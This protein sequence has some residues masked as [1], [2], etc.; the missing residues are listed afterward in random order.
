MT[1]TTSAGARSNKLPSDRLETKFKDKNPLYTRGEAITEANRCI[2]CVDAP[3]VSACPTGIDIPTFIHKIATD[4]VKGAARTIF[5]ANLLGY[6][7]ARVCPVEVLCAGSCVYNE[8][9]RAPIEIGRLQRYA[10]ENALGMAPDLV[11]RKKASATG[12]RIACIGAGPASLAVAGHLAL[13]G[14]AVEIF[15]QRTVGGGLNTTGV[16]PY[17]LMAEDSLKELEFIIGLGDITVRTGAKVVAGEAGE[18]EVSTA[19][20]I[21]QFDAVFIGIGLGPDNFLGVDGEE[22][23][24]VVGATA[25]IERL[26]L[27]PEANLEGIRT[28]LVV[29][30]GNTAID[31]AR[32]LALLGVPDVAMV[33][34]RTADV[35]SGYAHEMDGARREGVR[36][37]EN[38]QPTA[39]LRTDD[40]QLTGLRVKATD[41]NLEETLEAD[42]VALAIGQSRL[43]QLAEAFDGV[44]LDDKGRV[45]V[46]EATCQTGNPKVYAG[47]DCVNGGKEVVNAAQH[48]KLAAQA[49]TNAVR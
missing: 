9:G 49:I 17:K 47:G 42:L 29:G 33:Y 32:E 10:T 24:G 15:E 41:G 45:V 11:A 8:W 18:G 37:I 31:I 16:A 48:G 12:K 43:T 40:G 5:D 22:G 19:S 36:L 44:A 35:M 46:D 3:C 14:H 4:N 21:T 38:R 25:Y 2:Y 34:R 20:L 28:V 7:C 30:G 6:S 26:K 13:D 23:A 1:D 27:D 39:V